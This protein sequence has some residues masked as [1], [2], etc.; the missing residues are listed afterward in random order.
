[1]QIAV[2][3]E[4]DFPSLGN[5][6]RHR[7]SLVRRVGEGNAPGPGLSGQSKDKKREQETRDNSKNLH[8]KSFPSKTR[9]HQEA[10]GTSHTTRGEST[11]GILPVHLPPGGPVRVFGACLGL[12]TGSGGR[13]CHWPMSR[14]AASCCKVRP[15]PEPFGSRLLF[16]TNRWRGTPHSRFGSLVKG[17]LKVSP[18]ALRTRGELCDDF[19][20][21]KN[22]PPRVRRHEARGRLSW[23][24]AR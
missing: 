22:E 9:H 18:H 24:I 7:R 16:K 5:K 14:D 15:R 4:I 12:K 21:R 23:R 19:G 6:I 20:N 13:P 1:M 17:P 8:E 11:Q 10:T 3:L 2:R